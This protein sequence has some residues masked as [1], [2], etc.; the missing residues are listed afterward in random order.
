MTDNN[1]AFIG[2]IPGNYEKYLGPL[3]F[4]EYAE[5]LANRVSIPTGGILLE[6]AAGTGMATRQLRNAID[7]DIKIVVTDLNEDMLNVAR[8]K[9]GNDENVAFQTANALDLPFDDSSFDAIVCQFSVMF[10]PDK[11]LALQE[12]ARVLKAGGA[13]Y[14][15]IWDSFEHNHLVRSVNQTVI[16]CLPENPPT[17]F[18]VPYGYHDID[19]IKDLLFQ[20]GFGAIDISILPR[21]SLATEARH[22]ALGYVMGN[23]T[24]THI[25][26][27]APEALASVLDAVEQAIGKEFGFTSIN[28]KM[29][30]IVFQ[31]QYSG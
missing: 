20:A 7:Q 21:T 4:R 24:C 12:A 6:T 8:S 11:L 26:Q 9:F 17:F 1:S 22:V 15:N 29:Q 2:E 27:T 10:Y 18:Q 3:I 19:V 28:A 16:E 23:P 5:D 13:F 30:A 14:F 25:Q 31:A